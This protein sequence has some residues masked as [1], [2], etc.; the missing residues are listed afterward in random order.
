MGG[1]REIREV[2][3]LIRLCQTGFRQKNSELERWRLLTGLQAS[4]SSEISSSMFGKYRDCGQEGRVN[5]GI[6]Y[7]CFRFFSA[8]LQN[9]YKW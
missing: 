3:Q 9:T 1:G 4:H 7:L 6:L 8:V 5:K 2:Q